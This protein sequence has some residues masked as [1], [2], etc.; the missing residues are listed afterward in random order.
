MN[1]EPVAT[2]H[3]LGAIASV[4]LIMIGLVGSTVLGGPLFALPLLA[5]GM[6]LGWRV[7]PSFWRTVGHGLVGGAVAGLL[8]LGPG[9]RL[10]MRVVAILD[11]IRTPEFTW[12]GTLGIV[13]AVGGILGLVFG[14]SSA[15][16]MRALGRAVVSTTT[17]VLFMGLLL[18]GEDLRQELMELGA[19]PVVNIPLFA[20]VAAAFALVMTG[21][22]ER[23]ERRTVRVS[24]SPKRTRVLT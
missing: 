18:A 22:I 9:L 14:I 4:A 10:A 17:V 11:P 2:R 1:R 24:A 15:L 16:L 13:F 19:G 21:I 8:I 5:V 23:L 6:L 3:R 7:L 12:E 20:A